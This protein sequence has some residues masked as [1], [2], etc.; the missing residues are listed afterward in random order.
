MNY[1]EITILDRRI[2]G[3]ELEQNL[4]YVDLHEI[5]E[6]LYIDYGVT[7]IKQILTPSYA[8]YLIPVEELGRAI[9]LDYIYNPRLKSQEL[10]VTLLETDLATQLSMAKLG[11]KQE[12]VEFLEGCYQLKYYE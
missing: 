11:D 2:V 10:L 12:L 3:Y 9:L 8:K 6:W 7:E 4:W 1:A 5:S